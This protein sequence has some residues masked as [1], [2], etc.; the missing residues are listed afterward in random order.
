MKEFIPFNKDDIKLKIEDKFSEL[1]YDVGA[2]GNNM[3]LMAE[4]LSYAASIVNTNMAFG[5][6]DLTLIN[7]TQRKNILSLARQLGYEARQRISYQYKIYL[8]PT[9]P[10]VFPTTLLIPKYTEFKSG[11]LSYFYMGEDVNL[12][13]NESDFTAGSWNGEF[14]ELIVKEGLLKRYYDQVVTPLGDPNL[15]RT[16]EKIGVDDVETY[17]DIPYYD[18]EENGIEVFV[19]TYNSSGTAVKEEWAKRT[20]FIVEK[21]E[22]SELFEKR[23]LQLANIQYNTTRIYFKFAGIGNQLVEGTKV[24]MNI[25]QSSG[26]DGKPTEKIYSNPNGFEILPNLQSEVPYITGSNEESDESVKANAPLFYNSG[27]RLVTSVDYETFLEK[28]PLVKNSF[29]WG[30]EEELVKELGNVWFSLFK[31]ARETTFDNVGNNYQEFTRLSLDSAIEYLLLDTDIT[32]IKDKIDKL[33]VITM[34]LHSRQP[35]FVDYY[36]EVEIAQY[37][38]LTQTYLHNEFFKLIRTYFLEEMEDF[39]KKYFHT[40]LIRKLDNIL[41]ED[42]GFDIKFT[43]KIKL[44][45]E[46]LTKELNKD[47]KYIIM[48]STPYRN[49]FETT[50]D[51]QIITSELPNFGKTL[52]KNYLTLDRD[53]IV[54]FTTG[55]NTTKNDYL[56]EFPILLKGPDTW[57]EAVDPDHLNPPTIINEDVV[58]TY[59]VINTF[60]TQYIRIELIVDGTIITEADFATPVDFDVDFRTQNFNLIKTSIPRLASVKFI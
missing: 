54:D 46:Q 51:G 42:S 50:G 26:S 15:I 29:V 32:S 16:I 48:L 53:I 24:Y 25:L 17:L 35:I 56:I 3:S 36:Y 45:P 38:S 11:D 41:G 40:N 57:D 33:K 39:G 12:E 22:N 43:N 27:N 60:S 6:S 2:D 31:Q 9:V 28:E 8:R 37:N 49:Y 19:Q 59:Y 7:S 30:G 47:D 5:L 34:Q 10:S 1:G 21:D 52:F 44:F 23:Y 58:G 4:L 20:D 14:I 13:V 18:V 55:V